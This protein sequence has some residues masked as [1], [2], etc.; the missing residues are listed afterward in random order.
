[1]INLQL[2]GRFFLL[3]GALFIIIGGALILFGRIGIARL[4]GDIVIQRP[5]LTVYIPLAS[6]I[7]ISLILTILLNLIFWRG[8]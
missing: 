2:L 4:P 6:G 5:N 3:I 8:R 1:M 7:L